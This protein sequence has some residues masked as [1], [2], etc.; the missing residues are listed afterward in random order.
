MFSA[1][2]LFC[3]MSCGSTKN[4]VEVTT[5]GVKIERM[6]WQGASTGSM[7]PAWLEAVTNGDVDGVAK[8]L[9]I[10]SSKYKVFVIN[11][12]GKTLDFIKVWTEQ[13]DVVSE[14]AGS[15]SR[16]VGQTVKAD[17]KGNADDV[18][19][20]VEQAVT[21]ASSVE[22]IGLEKKAQ[23]WVK[24]RRLKTGVASP[25]SDA[26]YDS[27]VYTYYVVYAMENEVFNKS[28]KSAVERGITGNTDQQN[29]LKQIITSCLAKT[30]IPE[31]D[32]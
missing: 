19:K 28:L 13:V 23:Y 25:K 22:L 8:A 15:M 7:P 16:V 14:V 26:D 2:M 1:A 12:T 3:F 32:F 9:N 24:T 18:A 31:V 4:A 21:I 20:A 29:V 10:D 5:P 6:D 27:P 11:N 17:L 30:L